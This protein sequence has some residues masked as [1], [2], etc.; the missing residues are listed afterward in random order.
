MQI[1]LTDNL[2]VKTDRYNVILME[3]VLSTNRKT[4]EKIERWG[5]IQSHMVLPE[6]P[7][8]A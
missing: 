4:G 3:R 8:A 5:G 2:M 6:F 7:A 1:K